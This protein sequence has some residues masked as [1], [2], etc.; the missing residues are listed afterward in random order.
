MRRWNEKRCDSLPVP[1]ILSRIFCPGG[2]SNET[3]SF[4]SER[5]RSDGFAADGGFCKPCVVDATASYVSSDG[6]EV[7]KVKSTLV[8]AVHTPGPK[9]VEIGSV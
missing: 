4:R 9:L 5:G 1:N 6:L 7:G 2:T 3:A 8:D